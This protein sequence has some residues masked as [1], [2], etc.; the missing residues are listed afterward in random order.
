MK[1]ICFGKDQWSREEFALAYPFRLADT[2]AC[3]YIQEESCISGGKNPEHSEG[4]DNFSL[5][6]RE[7]YGYGSRIVTHS[8]FE[9]RGC[10][11]IIFVPEME[12]CPDGVNRYGACFEIVIYKNGVNV[13]RHYRDDGRCHWHKRLGLEFPLAGGEIHTLRAEVQKKYLIFELDG[14]KTILRAD[15]FPEKFHLGV[16]CCEGIARIYDMEI[17]TGVPST[18]QEEGGFE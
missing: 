6:T 1:N 13:W 16:T 8:S 7:T 15:D 3:G 5:L 2:C 11:E 12:V 17:E 10:T 18:V 14:T 4:F 9:G